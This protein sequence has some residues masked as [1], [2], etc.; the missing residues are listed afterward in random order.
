[1]KRSK[2]NRFLNS[3]I[4]FFTHE[5]IEGQDVERDCNTIGDG[6]NDDGL[7]QAPLG[8]EG[9]GVFI[10]NPTRVRRHVGRQWADGEASDDDIGWWPG[11]SAQHAKTEWRREHTLSTDY[12]EHTCLNCR[13]WL[14]GWSQVPGPRCYSVNQLVSWS[15]RVTFEYL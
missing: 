15:Y 2:M 13:G 4:F 14:V 12:F 7:K 8:K 9:L 6:G 11:S 1:M 3:R 10:W 5:A